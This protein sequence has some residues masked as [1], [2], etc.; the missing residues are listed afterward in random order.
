MNRWRRRA[1]WWL[2][3][4]AIFSAMAACGAEHPDYAIELAN[5]Y[6]LVRANQHE[7]FISDAMQRVI[8][9][10]KVVEYAVVGDVVVGRVTMPDWPDQDAKSLFDNVVEGYFLLNTAS[11]ERALGLT[12]AGLHEALREVGIQQ[13]PTLVAP[14]RP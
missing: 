7:V 1:A 13:I 11:Q 8:V 2:P 10:G 3:L 14:K 12:S 9:P 5:G 6:E 4:A